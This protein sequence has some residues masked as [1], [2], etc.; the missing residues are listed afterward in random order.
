[1]AEKVLKRTSKEA[2]DFMSEVKD[3]ITEGCELFTDDATVVAYTESLGFSIRSK[4]DDHEISIHINFFESGGILVNGLLNG[5]S[6]GQITLDWSDTKAVFDEAWGALIGLSLYRDYINLS[7]R[8]GESTI[9]IDWMDNLIAEFDE[10]MY[11]K[12]RTSFSEYVEYVRNITAD[13]NS[14]LAVHWHYKQD[15]CDLWVKFIEENNSGVSPWIRRAHV[16]TAMGYYAYLSNNGRFMCNDTVVNYM[17]PEFAFENKVIY[18]RTYGGKSDNVSIQE[19]MDVVN[20]PVH[21]IGEE[22]CELA[23]EMKD[24]ADSNGMITLNWDIFDDDDI[25]V[26]KRNLTDIFS[27]VRN[28]CRVYGIYIISVYITNED[29]SNPNGGLH[30]TVIKNN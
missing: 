26:I 2:F 1:M 17:L 16:W 24:E 11:E 23:N 7:R 6:I 9:H 15:W 18:R 21:R 14:F 20:N 25:K 30:L 28:F 10:K 27:F 19:N 3:A 13:R 29:L 12:M 22:I 5:V 8:N 4:Q